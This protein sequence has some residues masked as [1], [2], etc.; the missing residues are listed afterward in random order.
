[1]IEILE[2]NIFWV[3]RQTAIVHVN[4]C[5]RNFQKLSRNQNNLMRKQIMILRSLKLCEG[6][7]DPKI[8]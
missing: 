8:P 5:G 4:L 6:L 7:L 1:M 2:T 3:L